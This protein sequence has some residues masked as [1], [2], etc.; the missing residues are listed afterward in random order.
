M[1]RHSTRRHQRLAGPRRPRSSSDYDAPAAAISSARLALSWPLIS[2]RSAR[3]RT[4]SPRIAGTGGASSTLGSPK[5]V[6]NRS[7]VAAPECTIDISAPPRRPPHRSL[8]GADQSRL[9]MT[10]WRW[11]AAGNAPGDSRDR[12][13]EIEFANR[14]HSSPAPRHRNGPQ[15]RHQRRARSADQMRAFLRQVG[16]RQID[17]DN[18]SAAAT[19]P[20]ACSRRLNPLAAFGHR[21]VGQADDMHVDLARRPI[22]TCTS[23]GAL[24]RSPGMQPSQLSP[25]SPVRP[26][27]LPGLACN[28]KRFL[29][30]TAR[31][32]IKAQNME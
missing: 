30:G 17:G 25:P 21:L 16:R 3:L 9:P 8:A 28:A 14:P 6:G 18:A 29:P 22:I 11:I 2:A 13:V 26:R 32:A 15:R 1:P 20:E 31:P 10:H 27:A 4:G 12:A 19:S 24:R 23:T 5:V 7:E